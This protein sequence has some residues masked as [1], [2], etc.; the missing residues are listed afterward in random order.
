MAPVTGGVSDTEEDRFVLGERFGKG[1]FA[2]GI[3]I[4][5][6]VGML[7]EIGGG[8]GGETVHLFT[9]EDTRDTKIKWLHYIAGMLIYSSMRDLPRSHLGGIHHEVLS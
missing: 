3:P 5:G 4:H 7:E 1:F 2:P 6:V 8:G 9:T